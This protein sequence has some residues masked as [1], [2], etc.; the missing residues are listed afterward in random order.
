MVR[1]DELGEMLPSL[2]PSDN[3]PRSRAPYA[4]CLGNPWLGM[5]YGMTVRYP[6]FTEGVNCDPTQ[7]WKI[8]DDFGIDSSKMYGYWE[9]NVPVT[10]SDPDVKVTVYRRP[11]G[12]LLLSV[13][14]YTDDTRNVT[15][16]FDWES[17]DIDPAS[18]MITAPAIK[19]MQLAATWDPTS[20][21]EVLPRK[22]WLIYVTPTENRP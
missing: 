19:D 4:P 18:V 7:I 14:N 9:E 3:I 20:S 11:D 17:L 12:A 10:S 8:W 6:W 16:N 5:Q 2:P 13:G 15:L 21:I 22:G 1:C